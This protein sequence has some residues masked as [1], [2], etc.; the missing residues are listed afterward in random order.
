M[1]WLSLSIKFRI[2]VQRTCLRFYWFSPLQLSPPFLQ[3]PIQM[4]IKNTARHL[5]TRCVWTSIFTCLDISRIFWRRIFSFHYETV[6]IHLSGYQKGRCFVCNYI[7]SQTVPDV[8]G[9]NLPFLCQLCA[10]IVPNHFHFK[11]RTGRSAAS[12]VYTSANI[13]LAQ[14]VLPAIDSKTFTD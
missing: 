13:T 6:S 8:I 3:R 1:V 5:R 12:F 4:N 14:P 10:T 9:K 11:T 2:I 7:L